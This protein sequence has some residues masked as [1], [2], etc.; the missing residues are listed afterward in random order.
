MRN[1]LDRPRKTRTNIIKT[2]HHTICFWYL[3][4][5]VSE[6]ET[7]WVLTWMTDQM[8]FKFIFPPSCGLSRVFLSSDHRNAIE[9][10]F[11]IN[12][13]RDIG[14]VMTREILSAWMKSLHWTNTDRRLRVH[15]NFLWC[16]RFDFW[17][18]SI[19][20]AIDNFLRLFSSPTEQRKAFLKTLCLSWCRNGEWQWVLSPQPSINFLF[21]AT[22][23]IKFKDCKNAIYNVS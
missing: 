7:V 23:K 1:W 6:E 4:I 16:F 13:V 10:F 11:L 17:R 5:Y 15:F 8:L 19:L 3:L 14:N 20:K 12:A 22:S 21:Y 9:S 2:Q 18:R